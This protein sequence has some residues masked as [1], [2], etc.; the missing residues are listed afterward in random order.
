MEGGTGHRPAVLRYKKRKPRRKFYVE[1]LQPLT[2][3]NKYTTHTQFG[4]YNRAATNMN[5]TGGSL[6]RTRKAN[7]GIIQQQKAYFAR[8]RA[9]LQNVT[10]LP[11]TPFRPSYLNASREDGLPGQEASLA[12]RS[13]RHKG[14]TSKPR[15]QDLR[16]LSSDG[17]HKHHHGGS[18]RRALVSFHTGNPTNRAVEV[19][20][21]NVG[22][23]SPIWVL[24]SFICR[25]D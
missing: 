16:A 19:A 25:G 5:W 7:G 6:Q 10:N 17:Q 15:R 8:A 21:G 4:T 20:K 12:T 14:Q 11:T 18:S 23:K 24:R 13:L 3:I 9:H 22:G 2:T 1:A